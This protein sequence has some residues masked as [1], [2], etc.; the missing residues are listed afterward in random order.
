MTCEVRLQKAT[1]EAQKKRMCR[2]QTAILDG[3]TG[4][5]DCSAE[6]GQAADQPQTSFQLLSGAAA[7]LPQPVFAFL[8]I[9]LPLP[10]ALEH[11]KSYAQVKRS[12]CQDLCLS[13]RCVSYL[14]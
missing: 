14:R 2:G 7:I 4:P 6:L 13:G 9:P 5:P 3:S 1:T 12:Q 10:V 8:A 11:C